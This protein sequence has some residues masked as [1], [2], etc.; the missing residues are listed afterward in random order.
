MRSEKLTRLESRLVKAREGASSSLGLELRHGQR[1][2]LA[3]RICT[4]FKQALY[5][6]R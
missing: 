3:F 5:V 2:V 6:T 1:M 4:P